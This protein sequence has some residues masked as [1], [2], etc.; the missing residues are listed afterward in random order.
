MSRD[1][2]DT[3]RYYDTKKPDENSNILHR[4]LHVHKIWY[5]LYYLLYKGVLYNTVVVR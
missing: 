2:Y 5:V 4:V 3:I 1:M